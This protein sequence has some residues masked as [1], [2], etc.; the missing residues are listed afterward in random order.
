MAEEY[1]GRRRF[2]TERL[3]EIEGV[4]CQ[5]PEGAFYVFPSFRDLNLKS[6]ELVENLARKG[7]ILV[8]PGLAFGEAGKYHIRIP[9]VKPIEELGKVA[10]RLESVL[11][12]LKKGKG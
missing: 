10:E 9:L 12:E 3:N 4:K 1:D 6:V 7:R 5:L 11:R 2:M 8:H